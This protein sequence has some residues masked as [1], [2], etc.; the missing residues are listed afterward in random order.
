MDFFRVPAR[1]CSCVFVKDLDAVLPAVGRYSSY[2]ARFQYLDNEIAPVL[3]ALWK[4]GRLFAQFVYDLNFLFL[5][6][7][8]SWI[9]YSAMVFFSFLNLAYGL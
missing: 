7:M 8:A 4:E 3:G 2:R 5:P 9:F 1:A 6:F